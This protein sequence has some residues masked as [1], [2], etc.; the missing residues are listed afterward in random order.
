VVVPFF[1]FYVYV[2]NQNES[3]TNQRILFESKPTLTSTVANASNVL[4]CVRSLLKDVPNNDVPA[5]LK[6]M[7]ETFEEF[8]TDQSGTNR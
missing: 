2:S 3:F 4:D 5:K 1:L 8:L 7:T 6:C